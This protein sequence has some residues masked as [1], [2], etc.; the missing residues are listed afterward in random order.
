VSSDGPSYALSDR[1]LAVL[2]PEDPTETD[3]DL[4]AA[5]PEPGGNSFAYLVR[6]IDAALLVID[7]EDLDVDAPSLDQLLAIRGR[8][9]RR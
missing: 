1:E 7:R 8:V 2:D 6:A 5:E 4:A 3:D 9:V